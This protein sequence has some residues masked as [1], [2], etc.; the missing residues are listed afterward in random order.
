M[1]LVLNRSVD[2]E[3]IIGTGPQAIR[4]MVV[5]IQADKV[6]IGIQ[7]PRDVSVHRKEVFDSIQRNGRK[8]K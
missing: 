1:A 4:V 2:Q 5:D 6:K 7:A 3:I 8:T